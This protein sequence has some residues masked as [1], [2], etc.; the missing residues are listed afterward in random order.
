MRPAL[1]VLCAA[2]VACGGSIL[3]AIPEP[4]AA[5]PC[6]T[7]TCAA[8]AG[9][10]G[11][12]CV[13]D[14]G[15]TG[16][17]SA[18]VA[19]AA[20]ALGGCSLFPA[21]H[22]FNTPI[23]A[24]P[25]HAGSAAF[26]ARIGNH[27]LHLDLGQIEDMASSGYYGIPY[28]VVRSGTVGWSA[29]AFGNPG[30]DPR[31]ESDCAVA[32]GGGHAVVS[33]CTAAAAPTPLF[34]LP[35][36]PLVEGGLPASEATGGDHHLLVVDADACRLW[37]LYH[38]YRSTGG[39]G[40]WGAA[41]WDLSSNALRTDGW[42]SS[43]AAG[44]PVLPLLLRADEAS[45]GEI[46]HALR[47]TLPSTRSSHVWPARHHAGSGTAPDL[48]P[49]GQLF[50]LK[51]SF[52]IPATYSAQSKAILR[53]LQRYGMYLADNGSALYV[54][55]EPSAAW[56]DAIWSEVQTVRTADLEAVDLSSIA[57]RTGFDAGSARVPPP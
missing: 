1:L 2:A 57:G 24:F 21:D 34:P 50:R 35:A 27:P 52:V 18:C 17:A 33:P 49:M 14:P 45:S 38:F 54:Q 11:G 53:A 8:H 7:I 44:F 29:V 10:Q 46:R 3:P 28:N 47:F 13:C 25:V 9:C 6:A 42:T 16:P 5:D 48:A 36:A 56:S 22:V 41:S 12:A 4:P 20:P 37:E 32:S 30:W 31:A 39:W 26:L 40:S 51:S 15:Y 55:G 23:D 19:S 43:D